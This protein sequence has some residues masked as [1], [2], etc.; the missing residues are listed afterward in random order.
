MAAHQKGNDTESSI[1]CNA[2][3][4][5][6]AASTV[7]A[8]P[9]LSTTWRG[10]NVEV[11]LPYPDSTA[12][13]KDPNIPRAFQRVS[14]QDRFKRRTDIENPYVRIQTPTPAEPRAATMAGGSGSIAVSKSRARTGK[15][16]SNCNESSRH[17][18]LLDTDIGMEAWPISESSSGRNDV[19]KEAE[20]KDETEHETKMGQLLDLQE[21]NTEA[22]G[23]TEREKEAAKKSLLQQLY[24]LQGLDVDAVTTTTTTTTTITSIKTKPASAAASPG[25]F[26]TTKKQHGQA[27]QE[28]MP[29]DSLSTKDLSFSETHSDTEQPNAAV[30]TNNSFP[31]PPSASASNGH[32]ATPNTTTNTD[33]TPSSPSTIPQP[34]SPRVPHT[35]LETFR[36]QE[37]AHETNPPLGTEISTWAAAIDTAPPSFHNDEVAPKSEGGYVKRF[38]SRRGKANDTEPNKENA[39][40]KWDPFGGL[41]GYAANKKVWVVEKAKKEKKDEEKKDEGK[42]EDEMKEEFKKEK[43]EKNKDSRKKKETYFDELESFLNPT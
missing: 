21:Q 11:T 4:V 39:I 12:P 26:E 1:A 24:E 6:G 41:W 42:K 15:R 35:A 40:V 30:T 25:H 37:L 18:S 38:T 9:V 13:P 32:D 27:T 31:I 16:K 2:S 19:K 34:P 5:P 3:S 23:N 20:K 33:H 28:S 17:S 10:Q 36:S 7:S 8:R 43:E 22:A 29:S 14:E